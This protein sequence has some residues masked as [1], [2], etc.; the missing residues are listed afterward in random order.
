MGQNHRKS[1]EEWRQSLTPEQYEICRRKGTE[2][3]F[4]GKYW[5]CK[6][7]GV[8]RCVCCGNAL[9]SSETKFDSGTGWPSFTEAVDSKQVRLAEDLSHGMRRVEVLC[10]RCDAHLGHIF[11]D[12]PAP[13]G[14][15]FCINSAAL[16]LKRSDSSR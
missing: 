5:D 7:E 10:G 9:F 11:D 8:Y 3:S 12:G 2:R 13:A 15:R 1:D 4:T 16:D 14:T 6:E